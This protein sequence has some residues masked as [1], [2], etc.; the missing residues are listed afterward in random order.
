MPSFFV[1]AV[2]AD[3]VTS[4]CVISSSSS[5]LADNG[6]LL[7]DFYDDETDQMILTAA[8]RER[9]MSVMAVSFL[10]IPWIVAEVTM[11]YVIRCYATRCRHVGLQTE[12]E[13]ISWRFP[14]PPPQY[15]QWLRTL[16]KILHAH[17]AFASTLK[18]RNFIQLE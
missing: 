10:Y 7:T 15:P 2:V 12:S 8:S 4:D 5:R 11:H 16:I 6:I 17:L 9:L 1:V 14:S 18:W 3:G 13:M